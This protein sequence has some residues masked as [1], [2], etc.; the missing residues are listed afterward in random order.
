LSKRL[1]AALKENMI[2]L[3][4][5]DKVFASEWISEQYVA[6]GTK[7]S[8]LLVLEVDTNKLFSIPLLSNSQTTNNLSSCGI[9]DIGIS[10][11]DHYVATSGQNPNDLALYK[12]PTFDPL[13]IGQGHND[14]IFSLSWITDSVVVTGSRDSTMAVWTIP[15]N[16]YNDVYLAENVPS[17]EPSHAFCNNDSTCSSDKVRDL[18]V[19][20]PK[21]ILASL[22]STHC[23]AS[24]HFW[25]TCTFQQVAVSIMKH[26][27][28]NVCMSM[29]EDMSL[30]AV[31][32]RSHVTL[33]DPRVK[34]HE[35]SSMFLYSPDAGNGVRSVELNQGILSFGTG[36]GNVYFHDVR[37]SNNQ[38]SN[39]RDDMCLL[40]TSEGYLR[41]DDIYRDFFHHVEDLRHAIYTHKYNPCKTKLFVAGGPLPLGLYGS[42]AAVW[43]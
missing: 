14:W 2:S 6:F 40:K 1:P 25:D 27:A 8:K 43:Q 36:D 4:E 30:L 41:H 26:G 23:E 19:N 5:T 39:F 21:H 35:S 7:C 24:V 42:Y 12:Y 33:L 18:A 9:H 32:S 13:L 11:T 16:S 29:D 31:G 17:I 37:F 20:R 38:L 34:H 15:E 22:Q 3:N 28:E 10:P